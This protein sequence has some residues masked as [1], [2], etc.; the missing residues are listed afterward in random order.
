MIRA[1]KEC[2]NCHRVTEGIAAAIGLC[3]SCCPA[4]PPA[5]RIRAEAAHGDSRAAFCLPAASPR[6]PDGIQCK[7]CSNEC[8]IGEGAHGYCGLRTVREGRL[9]H[10]A[11]TPERGLLEW[12]RDPLP[13]N[14]VADWV[15]AGS[16]QRGRT[17]LAVFYAS[18]TADC[19]FCSEPPLL[20]ASTLLVSGHVDS[21]Q[22]RAHRFHSTDQPCRSNGPWKYS[23]PRAGRAS[24]TLT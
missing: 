17:N 14:C 10:L 20:V 5:V 7:L 23:V 15:C 11:G 2:M 16:R 9:T 19:F 6:D 3:P 22:V 24:I 13:T 1:R 18:C 4:N 12:Y 8:V 21:A